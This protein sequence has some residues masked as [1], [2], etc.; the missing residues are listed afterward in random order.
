MKYRTQRKVVNYHFDFG[1]RC[2]MEIEDE[3]KLKCLNDRL[4]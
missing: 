4:R 1:D 2:L 3:M